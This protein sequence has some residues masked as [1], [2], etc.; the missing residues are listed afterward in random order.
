MDVLRTLLVD[1]D[2]DAARS[3]AAILEARL[4]P[5]TVVPD[6]YQALTRHA[7]EPFDVVILEVALPGAN[8][9]D[10]LE[11]LVPPAP[12]VVLTWLVSPAITARALRAGAHSV[13]AK[14]CGIT[15]L[16]TAARAAARPRRDVDVVTV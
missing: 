10:L 14:P 2:V 5:T 15:D 6:V 11:R 13:L 3:L 9:I 8:G 1:D 16:L 4:G 12:A 7:E